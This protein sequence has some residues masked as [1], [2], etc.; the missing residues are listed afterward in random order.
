M[1]SDTKAMEEALQ[2]AVAKMNRGGTNGA[3]P[4]PLAADPL[5]LLMAV[6]PKLLESREPREDIVEKL[7][8]I[9][10]EELGPLREQVR[11]MRVQLHRLRKAQEE[12][13]E[14]LHQLREQQNAVGEAVLHL[15][16]QMA[17]FEIVED[18]D[19]V[20][21]ELDIYERPAPPPRSAA[22]TTRRSVSSP[23]T[24]TKN[25]RP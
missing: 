23:K 14:I 1:S 4:P 7:E 13:T 18:E 24:R 3:A 5:S 20:D 25:S 17:R 11:L 15:A 10:S 6:L 8:G 12:T 9:Q 19:D 22:P 21:D 16:N 2:A